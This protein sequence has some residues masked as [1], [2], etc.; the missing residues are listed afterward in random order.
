MAR[1]T[2]QTLPPLTPQPS[3]V[4]RGT[5][6]TLPPL[7][8]QP[9]LVARGTVQ[10]LPPL[11][12]QPSLVA[13]GTVQTLPPLT[14][15][16][17]LVAR[18]TVQTLP[19][20]TPQPSLVARGTV[21]TLPP[22]LE[23]QTHFIYLEIQTAPL[24]ALPRESEKAHLYLVVIPSR[25]KEGLVGMEVN[26]SDRP[27]GDEREVHERKDGYGHVATSNTHRHCLAT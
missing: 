15:Q 13:R 23:A 8:P 11:T 14:P 3:L 6:Q 25:D 10:T 5:V 20:L 22:R 12:P 19:P 4:A 18:G 16:P 26:P 27:W 9:S 2:V 21:Q 1:G 24:T 17:S 7:T